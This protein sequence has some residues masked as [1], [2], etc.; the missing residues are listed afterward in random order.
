MKRVD[1]NNRAQ[2]DKFGSGKPGFQGGNP[3]A[4]VLPTIPGADWFNHTQEEIC[5]VIE[6]A[7]LVLNP[8]KYN[9]LYEAIT[10]LLS[11]KLGNDGDQTIRNG[12]L[13]VG[14]ASA[15]AAIKI[16]S[17]SGTWE[18]ETNPQSSAAVPGSIRMGFKFVESGQSTKGIIM[19]ALSSGYE[20]VAYQSWVTEQIAG[21]QDLVRTAGNQN[22]N[23]A[24]TFSEILTAGRNNHWGFLRNP[25]ESGGH[26][27]FET[28]PKSN[29]ADGSTLKVNIKYEQTSGQARYIHF[30][31]LGSTNH[32]VA[33]QDW[34]TTRINA[35]TGGFDNKIEQAAPAGTV[36]YFAGRNA[37]A[38]WLKANGAAV[39]RTTYAGL[40]AAIG[41][42]YGAGDGR[43]T[44]NLPD[45]RGEFVRGWDDGRNI[46][47]G[48]SLGSNQSDNIAEHRH[49]TGWRAGSRGNE[50]VL[51]RSA[52]SGQSNITADVVAKGGAQI[53]GHDEH[54]VHVSG[55]T[56]ANS[57]DTYAT[58][59][60]Y[61]D[62]Q[63]ET[64]PR[65]VALLA[66]IKI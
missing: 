36:A 32:T 44:F 66:C 16:P 57:N 50:F 10:K 54:Y 6:N 21:A 8:N 65:N 31:E 29:Y 63:G 33:Y 5:S 48:R 42:T 41:T 24:K 3:A 12:T 40:F 23:G 27:V 56:Y 58:S 52:W 17:T 59:S 11:A 9:Q 34:V 15:W 19:P 46:D 18:I 7:G 30:P 61:Y 37:P 28:N 51:L 55:S 25:V 60:T 39:S 26:W 2:A 20:T 49:A 45:L 13:T 1:P 14:S 47:R 53:P 64:Y 43:T 62:K 22:I 35:A 38:G 4:G